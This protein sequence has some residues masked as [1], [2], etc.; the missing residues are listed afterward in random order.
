MS[1]TVI[2][3]PCYNEGKRLA[4]ETFLA[5][6]EHHQAL[7][8]LFVNDG[9]SD[10]TAAVLDGLRERARGGVE[11]QEL[12][13]NRGKAEAVRQGCLTA[14]AR[15]ADLI[16]YWDA[17]LA[18]PLDSIADFLEV[19]NG[20]PRIELVCGARVQLLGRSIERRWLR[21]C[22]GRFFAWAA[23]RTLGLPIYDTQCGA[24]LF[25]A[26]ERM[27]SVFREPFLTRWLL[28]VEI[29]A[30]LLAAER[31]G[32]LP[33]TEEVVYELP[34]RRW[35]DVAGSKVRAL[36]FPRALLELRTIS[37]RYLRPDAEAATVPASPL[38]VPGVTPA[39]YPASERPAA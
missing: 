16:G 13:R 19:L 5:F 10:D 8:F 1:S 26:S 7:R 17:D 33:P 18:T 25:R 20:Q 32:S 29:L 36:D 38:L 28:D 3:I 37:R 22:F 31:T 23:S 35:H 14:F 12:E 21:H 6:L 27:H 4:T 34:L 11:V 2:V 30:R 15:G 9:S 24:K 39:A